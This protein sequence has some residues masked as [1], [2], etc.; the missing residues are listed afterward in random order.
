MAQQHAANS[1][2]SQGDGFADDDPLAELARIVG[3]DQ[4]LKR[5]PV[6][7]LPPAPD[8]SSAEFNLEDELMREF[9]GYEQPV[10]AA[11]DMRAPEPVVVRAPM[12]D[13]PAPAAFREEPSF[14]PAATAYHLEMPSYAPAATPADE[15]EAETYVPQ[16]SAF[17]VEQ[18]EEP[19]ISAPEPVPSYEARISYD[20]ADELELAVADADI[21]PAPVV[22][23]EPPRLRLPLANFSAQVQPARR[24]EPELAPRA[25]A[26]EPIMPA[27]AQS[28]SVA[29]GA[30]SA[31]LAVEPAY[32]P[33]ATQ[34]PV[35][36]WA[37]GAFSFGQPQVNAPPI[38]VPE[39]DDFPAEAERVAPHS[40]LEPKAEPAPEVSARAEPDFAFDF[41]A[42]FS[43]DDEL[44]VTPEPVTA[45]AAPV[46]AAKAPT[47]QAKDEDFDPFADHD[48]DLKLDELD[49]ALDL[50]DVEPAA[51]MVPAVAVEA[52]NASAVAPSASPYPA[53]N[54]AAVSTPAVD[55]WLSQPVRSEPVAPVA[56]EPRIEPN[57]RFAAEPRSYA[58]VAS[59]PAAPVRSQP[60]APRPQ[61]I[62]PQAEAY[63]PPAY[64]VDDGFGFDPSEISE[65]EDHLES[66][67]ALDVPE[68]PVTESRPAAPVQSDY[69]ID[70]D[71]ELA[72]LFEE[73]AQPPQPQ[74]RTLGA[75]RVAAEP[76]VARA[77]AAPLDDFDAFEKALEEDLRSSLTSAR[78]ADPESRGHIKIA[79]EAQGFRFRRIKPYLMTGT[80]V[81]LLLA[82]AGG[83]YAWLGNG[84]VGSLTGGEPQIIAADKTPV[85]IVPE[86][87]GGKSVP[88]QDKAVYDRVAGNGVDDPKQPSLISSEEE[89]VDV[90]QRTLIPETM[91]LE[92]E[93]DAAA[94]PV[95]ETE[96]P[97]LLPDNQPQET[98]A[99]EEDPAT[100]TPRK[101]RTMIVRPDGTLVAQDGPA[102]P[103]PAATTAATAPAASPAVLAAPSVPSATGDAVKTVETRVVN[104]N[105]P[106]ETAAATPAASAP[107]TPPA[108]TAAATTTPAPGATEPAP[109]SVAEI[110]AASAVEDNSAPAAV[111]API[112]KT[113]PAEQ[114]VNVVGT[115]TDQGN[116]RPA[117]PASAE[118]AAPTQTA[119]ASP[120]AAPAAAP[121]GSYGIQIASLPSEAEAQRSYR[122]LSSKFGGLL[123]G[124]PYEIR[125]ADIPGKGIYYRVRIVAGTKDAAVALCEQYR[126]AGGTC[127]V[128]K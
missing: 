125:Q 110:A 79:G 60:I 31:P 80:A 71:A 99:A 101:V 4:P 114:P 112:P 38:V 58:P 22:Q 15:P 25:E 117:K 97:R 12:N 49:L 51:P 113:R 102:E 10:H 74:V 26:A 11:P 126:S 128:S 42:D 93:N 115:V 105:A 72:T 43:L 88:N 16:I 85:K 24:A 47:V 75:S 41:S 8:M 45:P 77:P 3:F 84:T 64:S 67:S 70:I 81:L 33:A 44:D 52:P 78:T 30:A 1:I 35:F 68:V 54:V 27:P 20:L 23:P 59:Q 13:A 21:R 100:I 106:I 87:P 124:K 122:S 69:D 94:T 39:L 65:Q 127:L 14:E 40:R 6:M 61:A 120:A 32:S 50:S 28:V 19:V 9:E 57:V 2:R 62:A 123:G 63:V 37:T 90:V 83:L 17:E 121:A 119:A 108:P 86:D 91:P 53:I 109:Q 96:D 55:A 48:F 66:V 98:A 7:S 82:G 5:E 76:V 103:A 34:E 104:P 56:V 36:E 107:A 46:V 111:F 116:L 29:G 89:P 18:Y 95:G 118:V 92:G 73:P